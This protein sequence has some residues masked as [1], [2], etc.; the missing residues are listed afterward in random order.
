M[1]LKVTTKIVS[2]SSLTYPSPISPKLSL[3]K[4]KYE[5][6]RIPDDGHDESQFGMVEPFKLLTDLLLYL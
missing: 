2:A 5:R 1:A 3:G 6:G 4:F